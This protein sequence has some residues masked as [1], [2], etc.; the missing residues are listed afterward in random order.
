MIS[1]V[2]CIFFACNNASN[3]NELS[4]SDIYSSVD[5]SV[6]FILTLTKSGYI[7]GSGFFID[8]NGTMV[9]NYHIVKNG[10]S[11][12]I[13][14]NDST[15]AIIDKVLGFNEEL[16]IAILST[17]AIN[18]KAIKI[19]QTPVQVGDTVYAIGYSST[20]TGVSSST[21]T[22]G[23]VSMNCSIDGR[24]YI[25]S[26]VDI[27][28]GNSGGVL[29]NKY[30][31][32]VGITTAGIKNGS[33]AP[34]NLSIP[35]Q[36]IDTVKRNINAPLDVVTKQNQPIH[37]T[38]YVDEKP[39]MIQSLRYESCAYEP[40][41]P[42]KEGYSFIGWFTDSSF[43]NTYDFNIKLKE[44]I[45][46]YAKFVLKEY[47]IYFDLD[48]G[49]WIGT[50]PSNTYTLNYSGIALPIPQKTG[51]LFDGWTDENDNYIDCYP[52]LY[53]VKDLSLHAK[54]IKGADG[55]EFVKNAGGYIV[56][57]YCGSSTSLVI[58]ST[59]KGL[60]V[61]GISEKAFLGCRD[62]VEVVVPNSVTSIGESAFK[63][64]S[65]LEK[66]TLPFIGASKTANKGYEQVF[67]YIFGYTT[68][69]ESSNIVNGATCQYSSTSAF[70]WYY[71]P[72]S[73]KT[74]AI[75]NV[76]TTIP[77]NA[78]FNCIEL[79]NIIIP[80]S[81]TIISQSAFWNC[82]KLKSVIIPDSVNSIA[83]WA[84][85]GCD[86]LECIVIGKGV[87]Y[88]GD[89]AFTGNSL[90]QIIVANENA[91]YHSVDNCLIETNSKT[92]ILGCSSS[93][94]PI[95]GSVTSIGERAFYDCNDL[96]CITIPDS[97][98]SIGGAAFYDCSGLL[99]IAI[100][101]MVNYI[102]TGAFEGC[103]KLD[104]I[105]V[106]K[107]NKFYTSVGNCLVETSSKR[108]IKGCNTSI[109]PNDGSIIDIGDWAFW[110][111]DK[112]VSVVIP[113]GVLS[114][115]WSAFSNCSGLT[116]ITIPSSV[117]SIS[118]CVFN[119]CS[120]LEQII[121]AGTI[122]QWNSIEKGYDWCE[123]ISECCKVVCSDGIINL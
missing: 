104:S 10:L 13:Q 34:M 50:A 72:T 95:D 89:G 29:I 15:T 108:L 4:A 114:I 103:V 88:I 48:N 83:D 87:K 41:E 35:I 117:I 39:Y 94:I 2:M 115:G 54:W 123:N 119:H 26:T 85:C 6:V 36:R 42:T 11:G 19:S 78:F 77:Y 49:D 16:D 118:G 107:E 28:D 105:F 47:E 113:N 110:Q 1:I 5:P 61:T 80:D 121:F 82:K 99:S 55:L 106:D 23:I 81:V 7:S 111:C 46:L 32:A 100:P 102:G 66:I 52:D 63:D 38:F 45:S 31:E 74:V 97:I 27:T 14:L 3:D 18:T 21:F 96:K 12:T 20:M 57:S 109:I 67:G 43:E 22:S 112:L 86:N 65:S 92:L 90:I 101:K 60:F 24:V 70:Y 69:K 40:D 53:S 68:V 93:I 51:Y 120:S 56:S 75:G 64:C 25:Q 79:T 62:L 76:A 9:T 122:E 58:P 8:S 59:Y 71:I 17:S 44:D 116:S 30:G 33:N 84:F 73:I 91:N 98:I 37:I